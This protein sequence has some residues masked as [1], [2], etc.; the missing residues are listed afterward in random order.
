MSTQTTNFNL[1]KD[2][3][4]DY[5]NI[6]TTNDNLDKIDKALGNTAKFET[7]GGSAT[8]I[9]LTYEGLSKGLSKSFIIAANNN[10]VA[11]TINGKSLYKP[12]TTIAPKLI[13]GKAVTVWYDETGDCFFI[14]ASAEGTAVVGNVL[15]DKTF[16]NDDDTGLV[17]TMTNN[18][19]VTI[20]PGATDQAIPTGYHNGTGKVTGD[21]DLISANIRAGVTIFGVAGNSNVID[22]ST[23]DA[24]AGEVLV[25]KKVGVDGAILTG[26]MPNRGAVTITPGATDQ[27]IPAGYHNGTGKVTGDADLIS[28]NIKAGVNIFG[29]AGN[30]NVI[31]TSAGD[32][33][34]G[35]ILAGKKAAVDGSMLTGTMTNKAGATTAAPTAAATGQATGIID[36]TVPAN[37]YYSTTSKLRITDADAIAANVAKDKNVFGIVGTLDGRL[38]NFPLSIQDAQPTA[39]R[40]G[41]IWVK[42]SA[43]AASVT[44][45]KILEALNAGETD[46]TLM[47]VVGD[48]VYRNE[49]VSHTKER[50]DG[51]S[52]TFSIADNTGITAGSGSWL[53]CQNSSGMTNTLYLNKPTVYSKVGG[54]LDT[55][56]AYY[57]NGSTWVLISQKGSYLLADGD[58]S[59]TFQGYVYNR[60]GDTLSFNSN[61]V[62]DKILLASGDGTYLVTDT[63]VYK[64]IGDVYALYFTIPASDS[65]YTGGVRVLNSRGKPRLC[66][67]R[68][69]NLLSIAYLHG[70]PIQYYL[71]NYID[72]GTTFEKSSYTPTIVANTV[73]SSGSYDQYKSCGID[74]NADGSVIIVAVILESSGSNGTKLYGFFKSETGYTVTGPVN[75]GCLNFGSFIMS[76][77]GVN[78][79][80]GDYDTYSLTRY[81]INVA[82]K[83]IGNG[84][85]VTTNTYTLAD[86][87]AHPAGY[88]FVPSGV[89][90][91][92]C[93]KISTHAVSNII[94]SSNFYTKGLSFNLSGDRM[95]ASNDNNGIFSYSIAISDPNITFTYISSLPMG[96][97]LMRRTRLIPY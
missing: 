27:T 64:R 66:I 1:T 52:M 12:G 32:A 46:G 54:V 51:G 85:I 65:S 62:P 88:I 57:W 60:V 21:A 74:M 53:V 7:A 70:N 24:S 56:T 49:S 75:A 94:P 43:L 41:H 17:G 48:L 45:V 40:A 11:T 29:V 59:G 31:D 86:A 42:S 39:V 19:A 4:T 90:G 16:S 72:N 76:Y 3:G 28:A 44:K 14:K 13:A 91:L 69:G 67:S 97:M 18:G 96:L 58:W 84:S 34:A 20:T 9:N 78:I 63:K 71:V 73:Y 80:W 77:N 5:Y 55:E 36:V 37:G 8:A 92:T 23:A 47:L 30:S 22:T 83:T 87:V 26:T 10:G 50:T 61:F 79:Y 38:Y 95:V 15:A 89:S 81:T 68:S 2:A 35:E 82:N 25:G 33:V 6:D 93:Y